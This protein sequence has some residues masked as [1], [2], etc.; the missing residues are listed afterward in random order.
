MGGGVAG[1]VTAENSEKTAAVFPGQGSQSPDMLAVY[2]AHPEI[3]AAVAE[4]AEVLGEDLPALIK[5]KTELDKTIN[6]QP[7]LLAVSVG[8]FRA[9]KIDFP[10]LLAGHSLGEYAALVCGG[11]LDFAAAVRLVRRRGELMARAAG[12]GMAAVIGDFAA[13]EKLCETAR[14]NGAK[15][16]A[17]NYNSPQQTVVAGDSAAVAACKEWTAAPGIKR[18][19]PLPVGVSSHCPLL[20]AAADL[21]LPELAAVRWKKPN[22]NIVH[23]AAPHGAPPSNIATILAAQLTQPVRWTETLARFAAAGITRVYECGPGGVLSGLA[24]RTPGAPAHAP[25]ASDAD[26]SAMGGAR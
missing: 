10:A 5:N 20:R 13:V 22:P 3:A 17:A 12:G 15:I 16:W 4:A 24:R 6:T 18:V 1:M 23:N 14:K 25:L 11:A 9:A 21:F 26:L 7:A 19:L 2:G 8:V